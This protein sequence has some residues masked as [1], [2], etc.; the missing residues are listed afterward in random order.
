MI[1]F[2]IRSRIVITELEVRSPRIGN[3][4]GTLLDHGG[5]LYP[6][7]KEHTASAQGV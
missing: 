5:A 7:G 1:S 4:V 6:G 3:A 2:Y